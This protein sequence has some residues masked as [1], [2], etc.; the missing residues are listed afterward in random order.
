MTT[1]HERQLLELNLKYSRLIDRGGTY[2]EWMELKHQYR[3]IGHVTNAQECHMKARKAKNDTRT[4][5]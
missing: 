1:A 5:R 2:S 3:A 4:T